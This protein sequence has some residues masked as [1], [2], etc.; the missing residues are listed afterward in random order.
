[1]LV[2]FLKKSTAAFLLL[3]VIGVLIFN[4]KLYYQPQYKASGTGSI[5]QGLLNQLNHLKAKM[6]NGAADDMQR[7]YPE[8]FV[9]LQAL[10]GLNWIELSESFEGGEQLYQEA[11][12]EINWVLKELSSKKAKQPFRQ[13]LKPSYG[14][15]YRGWS[16]YVLGR[17]IQSI[18]ETDRDTTEL[19]LFHHNCASIVDAL[20]KQESPFLES[21]YQACWP[22]DMMAGMASIAIHE[23]IFPG[24]Y[25][26]AIRNWLDKV[27]S[28]T[29]ASG[30][31]PHSCDCES[32]VP[33]ESARGS[34]QSLIL[35]FLID[36]DATYAKS[37]FD[38]YKERF[39]DYRIGLPGV[40][41]YPEGYR[42]NGD[43]DSGPVIWEIG[44]AASIVGQRTMAIYG[45]D[46]V[47]IGL[48]NSIEAFGMGKTIGRKK[49][50]LFGALP[51][52]DA[53]IAWSNAIEAQ[54]SNRLIANKNWRLKIQ[55][56]SLLLLI[57]GGLI[58]LRLLKKP[59]V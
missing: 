48:R 56:L 39:L 58:M 29:D 7:I 18:P 4:I 21:Y 12:E 8:G 27:E 2:N 23:E 49:N 50:Y 41:E 6:H 20:Q 51:I 55:L 54:K 36:I 52:A 3:I 17:K 24:E 59:T 22:A 14:I 25:R 1:M 16:N 44:G 38:I 42:G 43:I 45:E 11:Q 37:K 9:F 15:F 19:N 34:S 28:Q 13:N 53:F 57:L 5:H 30:L 33:I 26:Q 10:Y 32:G 47:A 40:R 46:D 31:I 35:N